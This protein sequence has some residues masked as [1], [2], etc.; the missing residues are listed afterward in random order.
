M[1]LL[2]AVPIAW[3]AVQQL[4]ER[5]DG[6][7]FDHEFTL[8]FHFA[9][10]VARVFG[11]SDE[12]SVRFEVPC[13]KDVNGETIRLDLL[14]WTDPNAKVAVELKAPLRSDSGMNSAMTQFRMRFYRDIHRLRHLV[15]SHHDGIAA[16]VFVAVVNERG[17][18]MESRQL[19][20]AAY[21]TYHGTRIAPAMTIPPAPLP[22]GYPFEMRMPA[23]EITWSWSCRDV[24]GRVECADGTKHFWLEPIVVRRA[25]A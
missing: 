11:F 10:E 19:V 4:V 12:L 2:D 7:R 13:G 8:Q 21:R 1:T 16:G 5:T 23:H 3:H 25:G 14:L 15:E 6:L 9:W 22:N 18:V 17:Y 24:G 20:N